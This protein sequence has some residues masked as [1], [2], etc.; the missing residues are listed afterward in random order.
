M[1]VIPFMNTEKLMD[2]PC[3]HQILP[4]HRVP[5]AKVLY[6]S[7]LT[8]S[9]PSRIPHPNV[10]PMIFYQ[11]GRPCHGSRGPLPSH[12]WGQYVHRFMRG[13]DHAK[14]TI[15]KTP[16]QT[17]HNG[18]HP[19]QRSCRR[20]AHRQPAETQSSDDDCMKDRREKYCLVKGYGPRWERTVLRA[21]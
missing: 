10:T 15:C 6:V 20:H 2:R 3:A 13:Y 11:Q 14:T 19:Y 1:I 8:D 9:Q 4:T 21:F 12:A 7:P 18:Q 17:L 16:I 5:I